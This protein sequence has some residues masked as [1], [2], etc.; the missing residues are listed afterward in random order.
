[1]TL[2]EADTK[3]AGAWNTFV[4]DHRQTLAVLVPPAITSPDG[5]TLAVTNDGVPAWEIVGNELV[6]GAED[7]RNHWTG[8][9]YHNGA[10]WEVS[11]DKAARSYATALIGQQATTG[12]EPEPE[13]VDIDVLEGTLARLAVDVP[14]FIYVDAPHANVLQSLAES[15]LAKCADQFSLHSVHPADDPN[16]TGFDDGDIALRMTTLAEGGDCNGGRSIVQRVL[17][18]PGMEATRIQGLDAVTNNAHSVILWVGANGVMIEADA[19]SA[20]TLDTYRPL[21]DAVAAA[22]RA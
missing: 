20:S 4:K 3:L 14:G 11:G 7:H 8:L 16:P 10:F 12:T 13:Q 17:T 21:L 1:V 9:W 18:T 5:K 15:G 6:L 19:S 2:V 22:S